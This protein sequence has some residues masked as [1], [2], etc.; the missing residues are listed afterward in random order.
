MPGRP[1][2]LNEIPLR[3]IDLAGEGEEAGEEAGLC[4]FLEVVVLREEDEAARHEG[5]VVGGLP[6]EGAGRCKGSQH[7][8]AYAASVRASGIA[9]DKGDLHRIPR[10]AVELEELFAGHHEVA[11]AESS[12]EKGRWVLAR[13]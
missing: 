5:G 10:G 8:R 7:G 13:P 12:A 4:V 3:G 2:T 1:M 6:L 9:A 11:G